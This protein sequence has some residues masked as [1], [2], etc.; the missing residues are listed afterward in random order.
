MA[1]IGGHGITVRLKQR[2]VVLLSVLGHVARIVNTGNSIVKRVPRGALS[3]TSMLPPCS[4]M[5]RRTIARP[6]PLPRRLVE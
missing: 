4:A 3:S 6:R 2:T 5:I 1:F